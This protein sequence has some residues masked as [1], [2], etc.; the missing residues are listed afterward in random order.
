MRILSTLFFTAAVSTLLAQDTTVVRTLTFDSITTRRGWWEFP[1]AAEQF[2]KV[3]MVHTLKC[4]PQTTWDQYPCGEWDYLTYH[5][6][7]EHTGVLDSTALQHPW[8][9]VGNAAPDTV[10]SSDLPAYH[11]HQRWNIRANV[12]SIGNGLFST[13]GSADTTD[14]ESFIS[15]KRRGQYLYTAQELAAAGLLA[16]P[17]HELRF[18]PVGPG[19][20]I[21]DR[22]VIR[23]KNTTDTA[24]TRFA[25]ED[26]MTVLDRALPVDTLALALTVPFVWDGTSNVIVD[27]ANE[28]WDETLLPVIEASHA[29]PGTALREIGPD[30]A[31]RTDNDFLGIDATPL[32]GL[33]NAVTITFRTYGAPQ[34]PLNTTVLEAVGAN[35]ERIVNIHLPWENGRIYWDAGSDGSAYDR[36]DRAA[37]ETEFEGSWTDWAFVKNASS[38]SMKIYKNGALWHS[39]TGKTKPLNGIV[40]MRVGSDANGA[41]PWPGMID[42]LNIFSTEVS[43]ATIAEWY[44][45]KTTS[46][47]PDF[48]SLLYSVEMDEGGYGGFPTCANA[49]G[50]NNQVWL[51]GTVKREERPATALFRNVQDPGTR[52]VITFGQGDYIVGFDSTIT[53]FPPHDFLPQLSREIFAV[54]GNSVVPV[55]TVFGISAGWTYTY[56][57]D[58]AVLDSVFA[59]GPLHLNDTLDYFGVPYEVVN[60]HEIGRY[61]TPYGIG[62]SLG[63]QG[64]SWVYDVT[65]Y[66]YLLHDSVEL[67]AGN[68]QELIDLTFLMIEG[69]A[70][71][72]LVNIQRPWGPMSSYSYAGL[73]DDTQL[74]PVT[75][76]LH[77]DADQW[78][79][80]SR[81]T[82]HGHN[83]NDGSYP[84][85][86]EWKD[87]T[88]YL[89]ADGQP[90]DEWHIWQENDCANNPVYPQGGTW[91]G[92]R[93]GWCPGNLVKDHDTE[94]TSYVTGDSLTIDYA[95][96]P[97]P[98]N[99]LGMGGGNYVINMDLFEFGAPSHAFDAEI[100]DV[101][102]PSDSGYRSRENPICNHPVV[103]LRNNGAET[104]NAVTFTYNVSG[105]EAVSYT[106]NGALAPN[107][108]SEVQLPV[109]TPNFWAGDG[110]NF[111]EVHIVGVNGGGPDGYAANDHYRTHFEMP[112]IYPENFLIWYKTNNRPQENQLFVR[113]MFGNAVFSRTV[114]AAN[115][116]YKDTLD[117]PPGCYE[118]EFTDSG[119]DGLSYWA[120]PDAGSGLFRFK[121]VG[122]SILRSFETEFGHR[123]Y[124]AFGIGTITGMNETNVQVSFT[125]RPNPSDGRFTL[126]AE[127]LSG[128][129]RLDVV[130]ATGRLVMSTG[131]SSLDDGNIP[132]DLTNEADGIYLVRLVHEGG[133]SLLRL[134]KR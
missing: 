87:N 8:F 124:T 52:P 113:D 125:A 36:I 110:G 58:G 4:D 70:P 98:Q 47:H 40:R 121:A 116:T 106:W 1:P 62:L 90:A 73:S 28:G 24:L 93:E 19:Q 109:Y 72:P 56:A 61:I 29:A 92:S 81:L 39:G 30:N 44:D 3:L 114:H 118:L 21:I 37:N 64:F 50:D 18:H 53:D 65:D 112:V 130:D 48:G 32:A 26:L 96:T 117:L 105:G 103:V 83:S 127:G 20:A 63:P 85:C 38:G 133:T 108:R 104:L 55:D 45:R 22:C 16:G 10:R 12:E 82:G 41:N 13:V 31:L 75:V 11:S 59:D 49:V 101:R 46:A 15:F 134:A 89:T 123:I 5:F 77:E 111:F 27:I 17:V 95:I 71:R 69:D 35:G 131:L 34:L 115:T 60:N 80:R 25:E 132:L 129:A 6:I 94:L 66:Q 57:P 74:A 91:L 54:Q 126:T 86:C 99:N 79:L 119:N 67:S 51:M 100:Y 33:N 23:M 14:A 84:H 97:V 76:G 9:K 7:H 68:T 2:R 78:M 42:G 107:Q 88:H 102:R 120:D 128:P 43:A 122:G